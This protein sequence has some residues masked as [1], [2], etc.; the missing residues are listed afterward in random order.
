MH[1]CFFP[2]RVCLLPPPKTLSY[3]L[4]GKMKDLLSQGLPDLFVGA[5]FSENMLETIKQ[6]C[7]C[8]FRTR[9]ENA[10]K[11]SVI[12][13][14]SVVKIKSHKFADSQI[15]RI[16][17]RETSPSQIFTR[18][19]ANF[20][21]GPCHASMF[22]CLQSKFFDASTTPILVNSPTIGQ[23]FTKKQSI[24]FLWSMAW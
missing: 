6:F 12:G 2:A 16:S 5:H 7:T 9:S 1:F 14:F 24:C 21:H 4:A 18:F 13:K 20:K 8:E 3:P 23:T 15:S 10:H 11:G 22:F 19:H 17:R